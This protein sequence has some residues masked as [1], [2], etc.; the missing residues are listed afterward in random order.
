MRIGLLLVGLAT[1]IPG[2]H[3]WRAKGALEGPTQR[4]IVIRYG[5]TVW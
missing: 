3:G 5:F 2:L 4:A 1:F